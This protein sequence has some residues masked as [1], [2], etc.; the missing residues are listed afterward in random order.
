MEKLDDI[1][2]KLKQLEILLTTVIEN[3][4]E[5][6]KEINMIFSDITYFESLVLKVMDKDNRRLLTR[7][8]F[9]H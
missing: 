9:H 3:Q 8:K 7:E 5:L 1:Q 4:L 6:K 2:V